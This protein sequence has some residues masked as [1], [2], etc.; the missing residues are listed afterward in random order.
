[1]RRSILLS[2]LAALVL[3]VPVAAGV[4]PAAAAGAPKW[5][6]DKA[7][8][9]LTFRSAFSGMAFEG[10]FKRWDADIAF[11]PKNLAASKAVVT[12]DLTSVA[13]GDQ[14]RDEAL[15][16]DDWFSTGKFH[17]A[18]FT[19]KVIKDLGGGKYQA[20]GDLSLRGVTKPV[21]LNFTLAITGAQAKMT[22]T[23]AVDRSQF[24]VG[25]GQFKSAETVPFGVTVN[26]SI[27][28]KRA[29]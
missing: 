14:D 23:A 1:M 12:V 4:K 29:G 8:S 2:A 11:D 17:N 24:G 27:V 5:V 3:I 10:G 6:V 18:T 26:V 21:L 20:T 28:A 16:T 7:A 25:Q 13:T 15:P 9:K 19:T 22:G